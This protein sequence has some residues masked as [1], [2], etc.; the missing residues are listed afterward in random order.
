MSCSPGVLQERRKQDIKRKDREATIE[1]V[2]KDILEYSR[3]CNALEQQ[4]ALI[5]MI[6]NSDK[7]ENAITN[8]E[9]LLLE[10]RKEQNSECSQEIALS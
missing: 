8:L 2:N 1:A 3:K 9:V 4:G 7:I 6:D 10:F 5:H